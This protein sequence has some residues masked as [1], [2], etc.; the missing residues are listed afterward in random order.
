MSSEAIT[1]EITRPVS[2]RLLWQ[3]QKVSGKLEEMPIE[4]HMIVLAI[5]AQLFEARKIAFQHGQQEKMAQKARE[6]A[7]AIR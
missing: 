2:E 5:L 1:Q 6:S 7:L 3:V 4:D